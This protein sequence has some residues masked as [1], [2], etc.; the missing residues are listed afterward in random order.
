MT[1][2][3]AL[4][5]EYEGT[6]YAGF[7]RQPH[8]P[9]VQSVLEEA[10]RSLTGEGLRVKAAGRTDAGVHASGQVVAFDTASRHTEETFRRGL[11]HY[12]PGDISV[13]EAHEVPP[14]FDPRRHAVA[15]RYRYTLLNRPGR[16]PLRRRFTCREGRPL[17]IQ[18][19]ARCLAYLEGERD[20]APFS[21]PME[22]GKIL[23]GAPTHGAAIKRRDER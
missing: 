8:A 13:K 6:A 15:R 22:S 23:N 4:V 5:L 16:S 12:L 1:R 21:G 17:D 14:D 9:T 10:I 11:D 7:Q 19:M 2:R 20:F 3:I 18:A